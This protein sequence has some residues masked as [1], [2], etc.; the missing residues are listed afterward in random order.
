MKSSLTDWEVTAEQIFNYDDPAAAINTGR[1]MARA[2]VTTL[3]NSEHLVLV[4]NFVYKVVEAYWYKTQSLQKVKRPL[5]DQYTKIAPRKLNRSVQGLAEAIGAAAAR[6]GIVEASYLLGNLY[7]AILPETIRTTGGMFY[8]PPALT[9]RL[10]SKAQ[11]HGVDWKSAT[12]IDPACGGGAFLAPV[13]LKMAETLKD[14]KPSQVILHLRSH[15][16]GW[17]I[18]PFGAWL[19]Q[20]FIEVAL[21]DIL[22]KSD[23]E[24]G[25][26]VKV[27]DSLGEMVKS[28]ISFDLV[29]GN[30]PYGKLKLTEAMRRDFGQSLYGHPNL[31]G[32]FTH[33][34]LQLASTN[35]IIAYLTPTSFLSGEY[36]KN[37]RSTIR[38]LAT[39]LEL[40][41]VS[42]RKGVF[43]DVL[44]ETMLT[45]Y[46]K[47]LYDGGKVK[48][49]QITTASGN[50]LL[51]KATG[52]F[53]LD[54]NPSAPWILPRSPE[55]A[56]Y[57]KA[58][59][60]MQ[61]K[62]EDWG[63]RISTGPLV[64]NRHKP[65][66]GALQKGTEC[67]PV[68]WSE[69][70]TQDGKFILRADKKNH[71]PL[72]HFKK[73]DEWLV[74]KKPCI[75]LQRTTA[76]EQEK[77]LVAAA[78]PDFLLQK[79][80][81]VENHLNMIIA[82]NNEVR[83]KPAVLAVFL[84]SRA[85]NEAFRTI[86]GSVAVSAYELESMPLPDFK[87]LELLTKLV[88]ENADKALIEEACE[89]IYTKQ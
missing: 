43:D 41:F 73:G 52:K 32:L 89:Q 40:D 21:A 9:S 58:M 27:C 39:P 46:R 45:I 47:N 63:Y 72:F 56:L 24:L 11:E 30:P 80:V 37:L 54:V 64:W 49:N 3:K 5:P 31:Y 18:D 82:I 20:V 62:L 66:L 44:Q 4:Q 55:Q 75:L 35:S 33:L 50:G 48:V 25:P 84:N 14:K 10:I 34:A 15:L 69:C 12:I 42:F 60:K 28:K 86:S 8:T 85:A 79:G 74:I 67:Y 6:L 22:A 26:M 78:L 1:V 68:I 38:Q 23:I 87:T 59:K 57:V 81:I 77:R 61:G 88:D 51:A 2:W 7:T 70:V 83:I 29:I 36:F 19:T 76:K 71:S 13:A 65:Q 53:S 17:E 16:T